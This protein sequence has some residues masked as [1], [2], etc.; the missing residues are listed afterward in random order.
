MLSCP[1]AVA[2]AAVASGAAL[3]AAV[4]AVAGGAAL[5]HRAVLLT[6]ALVVFTGPEVRAE[7]KTHTAGAARSGT[8]NLARVAR[9]AAKGE[10]A[11][12]GQLAQAVAD[13]LPRA[14]ERASR[15]RSR[16]DALEDERAAPPNLRCEPRQCH[17]QPARAGAVPS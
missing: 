14:D 2:S 3:P 6:T 15:W 12:V 13:L 9:R 11:V 10:V 16:V 4:C 7:E 5:V 8:A 17:R 1:N